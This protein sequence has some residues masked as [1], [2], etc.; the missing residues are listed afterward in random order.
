[1]M[2]LYCDMHKDYEGNLSAKIDDIIRRAR[3]QD[4]AKTGRKKDFWDKLS[5]SSTVISGLFVGLI[6]IIA[7]A[8]YNHR[9]LENQRVRARGQY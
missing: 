7:T 1:M 2:L 4:A 8:T 5:S 3:S 6:G 9:E